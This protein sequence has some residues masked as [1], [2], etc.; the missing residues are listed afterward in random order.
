MS[1]STTTTASFILTKYSRS[2]ASASTRN[3][4]ATENEWQ[5]FTNPVV[6]LHL[7]AKKSP[8]GELISLRLR[9]VWSIEM[10]GNDVNA[11]HREVVFEDLELLSFSSLP[12]LR[13]PNNSDQGLPLKAVYRDTVVGIRYLHPKS[14]LPGSPPAYRR[15]QIT[16]TNLLGASQF[17]DTI[18]PVC[19]CK[20]NPQPTQANRHTTIVPSSSL[21]R[22]STIST[23]TDST[24]PSEL[25]M[26]PPNVASFRSAYSHH[27]PSSN[28]LPV[29]GK[30]GSSMVTMTA[31]R[32]WISDVAV[33]S[34]GMMHSSEDGSFVTCPDTPRSTNVPENQR[35][36]IE[37]LNPSS[38]SLSSSSQ[39]YSSSYSSG[40][41]RNVP[42]PISETPEDTG[43]SVLLAS[44]HD[45][46]SLYSLARP[47]LECLVSQVVREEGFVH[48]L[49]SLD[50]LWRGKGFLPR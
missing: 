15:F 13:V 23:V 17:I 29:L 3:Q 7:D 1:L 19:P 32:Q 45:V 25:P 43:Q 33:P 50:S 48:L 47:D 11:D 44:L 28:G 5:H 16:F 26:M 6:R 8:S 34:M 30:P 49:D 18:K 38:T 22:T 12:T 20:A 46:S 31:P 39:P 21:A 42:R 27:N 40:M 35:K 24:L 36:T 9:I 14:I 41:T 37:I 4:P 10:Q 2:Y